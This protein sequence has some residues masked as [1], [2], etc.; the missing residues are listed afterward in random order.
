MAPAID[1]HF[2]QSLPP[3]STSPTMHLDVHSLT[4]PLTET[5]S[6]SDGAVARA[7]RSLAA[8]RTT[9]NGIT[10]MVEALRISKPPRAPLKSSTN[11]PLS[12]SIRRHELIPL[13][14]GRDK[15]EARIRALEDSLTA[16][17]DASITLKRQLGR[18]LVKR[19]HLE[20]DRDA[21]AIR[22]STAISSARSYHALAVS[23]RSEFKVLIDAVSITILDTA[24]ANHDHQ[25]FSETN[26]IQI[27]SEITSNP[28]VTV[29]E[30]GNCIMT[31]ADAVQCAA[32]RLQTPLPPCMTES[33]VPSPSTPLVSRSRPAHSASPRALSTSPSDDDSRSCASFTSSVLGDDREAQIESLIELIDILD[34]KLSSGIPHTAASNALTRARRTISKI[35]PKQNPEQCKTDTSDQCEDLV[36][37]IDEKLTNRKRK[38]AIVH[39]VEDM[40]SGRLGSKEN[41][42]GLSLNEA[43][44]LAASSKV[45]LEE[46]HQEMEDM[47]KKIASLEKA[48]ERGL[49]YDEVVEQN[50]VLEGKLTTA[51]KTI[52]RLIQDTRGSRKMPSKVT[53][54]SQSV[55]SS[56][57]RSKVG[58]GDPE[59]VQR[60]LRWRQTATSGTVS[61]NKPNLPP[62]YRKYEMA[63]EEEAEDVDF[64]E[65]EKAPV[66]VP[67]NKCVDARPDRL[68][69]GEAKQ[70]P[71]RSLASPVITSPRHSQNENDQTGATGVTSLNLVEATEEFC[72]KGEIDNPNESA[73]ESADMLT[74][75]VDSISSAQV[76]GYL[77]LG[78][79]STRSISEDDITMIRS[80]NIFGLGIRHTDG[81]RGLLG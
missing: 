3:Q 39:A 77:R 61:T 44:A 38:D 36:K 5:R 54:G 70:M 78:T 4:D 67:G 50:S 74:S 57:A 27:A 64:D 72:R 11:T 23:T 17:D 62:R 26:L 8:S 71:E 12:T 53:L 9:R 18:A 60:I 16:R 43:I 15:L 51:K 75:E 32:N 7:R 24:N 59:A 35:H 45:E 80:Q 30:L 6:T 33:K 28:H 19:R 41:G 58:R 25:N 2:H 63:A 68:A 22:L 29:E 79:G 81:L 76:H 40:L 20:K 55:E 21:I 13:A 56:P 1:P 52:A 65:A 42:R 47:R 48:A 69:G 66:N 10:S 49:K 37:T 46:A 14:E 73:M 34:A 31:V